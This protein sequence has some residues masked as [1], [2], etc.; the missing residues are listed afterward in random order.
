MNCRAFRDQY[1]FTL[2]TKPP[3]IVT[4]EMSEHMDSCRG[5]RSYA[6]AMADIDAGL[7]NLPDVEVPADLEERLLSIPSIYAKQVYGRSRREEI[8]HTV[9]CV[10]PMIL[11]ALVALS[12][13]PE[14]RLLI[15]TAILASAFVPIT[16]QQLRRLSLNTV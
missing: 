16:L 1:D 2:D 14:Y 12:L 15:Q 7:R 13:A 5:C 11:T 6:L 10:F 4:N 9:V 8:R 3:H